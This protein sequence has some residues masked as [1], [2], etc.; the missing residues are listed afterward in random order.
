MVKC[1]DYCIHDFWY[2]V[3][4]VL[5]WFSG[6]DGFVPLLA[7][8]PFVCPLTPPYVVG[9]DADNGKWL[10]ANVWVYEGLLIKTPVTFTG[11]LEAAGAAPVFGAGA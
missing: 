10:Q 1:R 9:E 7:F 6:A 8:V 2:D 4:T 11:K 5:G 3:F